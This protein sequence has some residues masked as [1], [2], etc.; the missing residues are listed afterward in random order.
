MTSNRQQLPQNELPC[1]VDSGVITLVAVALGVPPTE[2]SLDQEPGH[3]VDRI[4]L[5]F[6]IDGRPDVYAVFERGGGPSGPWARTSADIIVSE[7]AQWPSHP[8]T[9]IGLAADP[10]STWI[11]E[12]TGWLSARS[13]SGRSSGVSG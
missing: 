12:V 6:A 2:G 5:R 13:A 11:N 10:F 9:D 8:P 4:I 7:L 3:R 1:R